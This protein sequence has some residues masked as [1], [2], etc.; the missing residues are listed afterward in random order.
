MNKL[1]RLLSGS[2]SAFLAL[3]TGFG[4]T[5]TTPIA[6]QEESSGSE[7]K[8]FSSFNQALH[9]IIRHWHTSAEAKGQSKLDSGL[10]EGFVV[11][12]DISKPTISGFD[13][14]VYLMDEATKKDKL[15]KIETGSFKTDLKYSQ[16]RTYID[17]FDTASG[18][19]TFVKNQKQEKGVDQ[20]TFA[21]FSFSAGQ[22]AVTIN[23]NSDNSTPIDS[24]IVEYNPLVHLVKGHI[25]YLDET[26]TVTAGG[27]NIFSKEIS[28]DGEHDTAYVYVY[29]QTNGDHRQGDL[30]LDSNGSPVFDGEELP[31]GVS[32]DIVQLVKI[33]DS[34]EGLHTDKSVSAVP[35]TEREFD[36]DLEAWYSGAKPIKV[37]M[38]LD[39][40]G[41][42]G[43]TTDELAPIKVD[44]ALIANEHLPQ[45]G[46]NT[47]GSAVASTFQNWNSLFLDQAKI[48]LILD[49]HNTDNSSISSAGFTYFVYD[50]RDTVREYV[51]LGYWNGTNSGKSGDYTIATNDGNVLAGT[52]KF[53]GEGWYYVNPNSDL[54][55]LYY[56]QNVQSGKTLVGIQQTDSSSITFD[57][58][59]SRSIANSPLENAAAL[60]D[61][62]SKVGPTG[63]WTPPNNIKGP[64]K[65]YI[66]AN[67]YLRCFYSSGTG[68]QQWGTSYVY[69]KPDSGYIK[70]EALQRAV[71]TFTTKLH[72]LS[73]S[74]QVS[75][76]RFSSDNA[77]SDVAPTNYWKKLAMLD[78]TNDPEDAAQIMSLKRGDGGTVKGDTSKGGL[79]QFNFGLTGGTF[80]Y[81]GLKA[82]ENY[83][84]QNDKSSDPEEK[85]LILFTDGKDSYLNKELGTVPKGTTQAQLENLIRNPQNPKITDTGKGEYQSCAEVITRLKNKG[86]TLI[87]VMLSGGPVKKNDDGTIGDYEI[88]KTF[89][90]MLAK[91]S[92]TDSNKSIRKFYS[93]EEFESLEGFENY[94]DDEDANSNVNALVN[95]FARDILGEIAEYLEGYSVQDTI[96]PRF[97][98]IDAQNRVWNLDDNG[99][100][101]I[102]DKAGAVLGSVD[103][104]Q[105]ADGQNDSELAEM[106][107]SPQTSDGKTY[108]RVQL[109]NNN[110]AGVDKSAH[111]ADLLFDMDEHTYYLKWDG[112]NIPSSV[113]GSD[114]IKVWKSQ[115]RLLAKDDFIGGNAVLTNGNTS[116]DNY[117]FDP[118][119]DK[120]SSGTDRAVIKA[121]VTS[122]SKGFPRVV[123]NVGPQK[124]V[125]P[126]NDRIFL[127]EVYDVRDQFDQFFRKSL[128]TYK[129]VEDLKEAL[130]KN[131]S[132][133]FESCNENYKETSIY[134]G[135]LERFGWHLA[136]LNEVAGDELYDLF[137]QA[138]EGNADLNLNEVKASLDEVIKKSESQEKKYVQILSLL[139]DCL[140]PEYDLKELEGGQLKDQQARLVIPYAYLDNLSSENKNNS[141]FDNHQKEIFG[142]LTF[143]ATIPAGTLSTVIDEKDGVTKS[144]DTRRIAF[145]VSFEHLD[146]V[147]RVNQLESLVDE[148][149]PGTGSQNQIYGWDKEYKPAA[150]PEL[151]ND[152]DFNQK[153]DGTFGTTESIHEDQKDIVSGALALVFE[154]PDVFNSYLG[155]D[156]EVVSVKADVWR[157]FKRNGESYSEKIGVLQSNYAL[158][159]EEDDPINRMSNIFT[160]ADNSPYK[161]EDT[162]PLGTYYLDLKSMQLLGSP[163]PELKLKAIQKVVSDDY[164]AQLAPNLFEGKEGFFKEATIPGKKE[165]EKN[166]TFADL[167]AKSNKEGRFILGS[168]EDGAEDSE[169]L[170]ERFG[171][172]EVSLYTDSD[173]DAVSP[174]AGSLVSN[175]DIIEYQI[176]Y[177]NPVDENEILILDPIDPSVEFESA[178]VNKG[179]ENEVILSKGDYQKVNGDISIYY[180][181]GTNMTITQA[182]EQLTDVEQGIKTVDAQA[183]K[184]INNVTSG[185][186]FNKNNGY[187]AYYLKNQAKTAPDTKDSV[188]LKVKV[189]NLPEFTA[190]PIKI[191]NQALVRPNHSLFTFT[192]EIEHEYLSVQKSSDP[193]NGSTVEI[194]DS[195]TYTIDWTNPVQLDNA[196]I[197]VSDTLDPGLTFKSASVVGSPAVLT[198][199]DGDSAYSETFESEKVTISYNPNTREVRWGF[200][201]QAK[202]A[203]GQVQ[204]EVIVNDN[205]IFTWTTEN[206]TLNP[207]STDYEVQNI[208]TVSGSATDPSGNEK[209]RTLKTRKQRHDIKPPVP[210][211]KETKIDGV[212]AEP[213][214]TS[215]EGDITYQQVDPGQKVEYEIFWINNTRDAAQMQVEDK[216]DSQVDF[217]DASDG[218]S[219]DEQT[220]TV[221]WDLEEQGPGQSGTVSVKVQV[222]PNATSSIENDATIRIGNTPITTQSAINTVTSYNPVPVSLEGSKTLEGKALVGGDFTFSVTPL[223]NNA[224]DPI[225]EEFTVTNGADGTIQ[226]FN[227]VPFKFP[228]TFVYQ[229]SETRPVNGEHIKGVIYS[230]QVYTVTVRI[231]ES[232]TEPGQL[233]SDIVIK[234][235]GSEETP[236]QVEFGNV[237][238]PDKVQ[239]SIGGSKQLDDLN[240]SDFNG[241]FTFIIEAL[242]ETGDDSSDVGNG[243]GSDDSATKAGAGIPMPSK[244]QVKN[245]DGSFSFGEIEFTKPG[246]YRYRVSELEGDVFGVVSWD[247]RNYIITVTVTGDEDALDASVSIQIEGGEDVEDITFENKGNHKLFLNPDL[248]IEKQHKSSL[249]EDFHKNDIALTFDEEGMAYVDYLLTISNDEEVE[250]NGIV[251]KDPVPEGLTVDESSF[252]VTSKLEGHEHDAPVLEDQVIVWT[253][254]LDE[255]ETIE[256]SFRVSVNRANQPTYWINHAYLMSNDL[257]EQR[258]HEDSFDHLET[259]NCKD[260]E[261]FISE[262]PSED[263]D[264]N[265]LFADDVK[266]F[267]EPVPELVIEKK[268]H[269]SSQKEFHEKDIELSFK[270]KDSD[271]VYYQLVVSNETNTSYRDAV[272]KDPI[273]AGLV[274]DKNSLKAE[275]ADGTALESPRYEDG[276][277]VWTGDVKAKS[278]VV[279]S[280]A[281]K[282]NKTSLPTYW[283]NHAYLIGDDLSPQEPHEDDFDDLETPNC[284]DPEIFVSEDPDEEKDA[285]KHFTKD[286]KIFTEPVPELVIEKKHHSSSQ[287][288]FHTDDIELSFRNKDSDT[289]YYQVEVSNK[290][291]TDFKGAT[292]KDPIPAGLTIDKD[293]LKA[294]NSDGTILTAPTFE[295]GCV[296]WSGDVKANSSILITFAVS[297]NKISMPTYWINH[298]Y[299]IGEDLNDPEDHD[300]DFDDLNDPD[301]PTTINQSKDPEKD[302][303]RNK[304]HSKDVKIHAEPEDSNIEII[305]KQQVNSKGDP[306][307]ETLTVQ[308]EDVVTYY[309]TVKN[310][311]KADSDEVVVRDALVDGLQLVE[312][313]ISD[314]GFV[315]EDS[316][317]TVIVWKLGALKAKEEKTVSF[318]VVVPVVSQAT[319]WTNTATAKNGEEDEI[320]SN[321]VKIVFTPEKEQ[322][323]PE[324]SKPSAGINGPNTQDPAASSGTSNSTGTSN[325]YITSSTNDPASS[326]IT[327]K[328]TQELVAKAVNTGVEDHRYLYVAM[329]LGSAAILA[330]LGVYRRKRLCK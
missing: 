50:K 28:H 124:N 81:S 123:A 328:A 192:K 230:D 235:N 176:S 290:T 249:E 241:S 216:L 271:T 299:V 164:Y 172:W 186:V 34:S 317:Q 57:N 202:E 51:P 188:F 16:L 190:T 148:Y 174:E 268:H 277:I 307:T 41:S 239:V 196:E 80:T 98:L 288:N 56:A 245:T 91:E 264:K 217:V 279:I 228:G 58:T 55:N 275:S 212:D 257:K 168:V 9:F 302:K 141:G 238:D 227:E 189:A 158:N 37:G 236:A 96:D 298:A 203:Y 165:D 229:V 125:D 306:V 144:L 139:V 242:N 225:G 187:V 14:Y 282:V 121:G 313:S 265:R 315:D 149:H 7:V 118:N 64:L 320:K 23:N 74:S 130:E 244:T 173:K 166:L 220:H 159:S 110:N 31:S 104:T 314:D 132:V 40:S 75:A 54:N 8:D 83:L 232:E 53:T 26:E 297:V 126:E 36:V 88:A 197:I 224:A 169:Y 32:A 324:T 294:E 101:T 178:T 193:E 325:R 304:L 153:E 111:Q 109:T 17:S 233:V 145:N 15:T 308:G 287:E 85:F 303:D 1:K 137:L 195:I 309:L 251:V 253:G 300:D 283:I 102:T 107:I 154:D 42:M 73:P 180:I 252:K 52:N 321:E 68:D 86:Y 106:G 112:Q 262:D 170:K 136:S 276:C 11:P 78:W 214:S 82:F 218:G 33:Y 89:L 4:S 131:D 49:K 103:L 35:G 133:S 221:T 167:K 261:I 95:I 327:P 269:S 312:D 263:K 105:P 175:G 99:Q 248:S 43:F 292:I 258:P 3:Q 273:P 296:V 226:I 155:A 127:G 24:F 117:V 182:L 259:P 272:V 240:I 295:D 161:E 270:D 138:N 267:A 46:K 25:F 45:I 323:T 92:E 128:S 22:G 113:S 72:E 151:M 69:M 66:D 205:S 27:G 199:R 160:W 38:V 255:N 247:K 191:H 18:K 281:V 60:T 140:F 150:Y 44:P 210:V 94:F 6:A 266:I 284:K 171:I 316:E 209:D 79:E 181:S 71:G 185:S 280:F 146:I 234:L 243:S 120:A 10:I 326:A 223:N 61:D 198:S 179:K 254:D 59:V 215:E 231:T 21:G 115:I 219:Y 70:V 108:V 122:V 246:I 134:W 311:S 30:V 201:G 207:K 163:D 84:A 206:P 29:S 200:T 250:A 157:S 293:S 65:L 194:G 237:Y 48:D 162:L 256:I 77:T 211:K 329:V 305:K 119:D 278:H 143:T 301:N 286:V 12:K 87:T 184:E 90:Q 129:N 152:N 2:L 62:A 47:D 183:Q 319:S 274:V 142:T 97:D 5:C 208:A 20:E 67:G 114:R 289:V 147:E 13:F 135:Y 322:E 63:L 39:A 156:G 19:I 177:Y 116:L 291:K 204:V 222:H 310:T 93:T 100:V 260:P 318:K 330:G 213:I 285:N 76:V